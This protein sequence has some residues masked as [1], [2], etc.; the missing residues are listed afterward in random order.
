[1]LRLLQRRQ[2]GETGVIS[3]SGSPQSKKQTN[4]DYAVNETV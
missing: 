4:A 1:M 2:G 3:V